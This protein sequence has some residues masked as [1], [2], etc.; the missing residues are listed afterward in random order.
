MKTV[1]YRTFPIPITCTELDGGPTVITIEKSSARADV[2]IVVG[3]GAS[4]DVLAGTAH[5]LEHI[6]I[7]NDQQRELREVMLA[8]YATNGHTSRAA[9]EYTA[10]GPVNRLELLFNALA[11]CIAHPIF[12][13]RLFQRELAII[14]HEIREEYHS[15]QLQQCVQ[16]ALYPNHTELHASILGSAKDIR[17]IRMRYLKAYHEKHYVRRNMLVIACGSISHHRLV[18]IVQRSSCMSLPEGVRREQSYVRFSPTQDIFKKSW[19]ASPSVQLYL[20]MPVQEH[21]RHIAHI[22]A[23]I[24]NTDDCGTL[25]KRLRLSERKVYS[26]FQENSVFPESWMSIGVN[27]SKRII[28]SLEQVLRDEIAKLVSGK[29]PQDAWSRVMG[30]WKYFFDTIE[31][32]SKDW[33]ID[34]FIRRW[35]TRDL[36]DHWFK[37]SILNA[38]QK[39]VHALIS[40]I[41][42]PNR[43]ARFRFIS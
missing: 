31:E 24:L 7:T 19:I 4:S 12:D 43:L 29:F 40:T 28:P 15:D 37:N 2:R 3:S 17:L 18:E 20:P 42:Q 35:Q 41:W 38:T 10:N 16:N 23:E 27:V 6:C 13:T 8:G 30:D 21:Q 14:L 1:E 9:T 32:E 5:M 36:K 26:S 33:Y 25:Y 39:E 34:Y 11:V 22:A